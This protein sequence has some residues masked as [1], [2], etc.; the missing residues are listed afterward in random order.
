[1][2]KFPPVE[3]QLEAILRG[4]V[5]CY[6][7]EDLKKRLTASRES[8]K[9][10]RV[11]LG[12]DPTAPNIHIGHTVVLGKMRLFQDFGHTAV[13]IVGDYTAM[14]GDP[15]GKSK[16]RKSMT[17]DE[18]NAAAKTYFDQVGTVIDVKKAEIRRN[19]EWFSKMSFGD[20]MRLAGRITV[21]RI[22]ERDDFAKR[23]ANQTPISLHELMYPMMQAYDSIAI[24]ADVELGGTDQTFNLLMGRRLMEDSNLKPQICLTTPLLPGLDGVEKMSKSL[25]NTIDVF[26]PPDEM[27]GKT[28]SI[29][30][31]QMRN[32]FTLL[33]RIPMA[34]VEILLDPKQ[35]NPRMSKDRLAQEIVARY[36]GPDA[37]KKASEE[38]ARR[39]RDKGLPTDIPTHKPSGAIVPI[40]DLLLEVG[41]SASKGEARRS[42]EQKGVRLIDEKASADGEVIADVNAKIETR[43]GL[44]LRLGKHRYVRFS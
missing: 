35:T 14:V 11:K 2:T 34:E 18:V 24:E 10:L 37:A 19:G 1:M 17:E 28:M 41:F 27:F 6:S 44:I 21:A 4:A 8:G 25:G 23:Y 15:S 36:H 7:A 42:I 12:L 22:L 29:A 31:S 43:K 39:F 30:D 9:P 38:F 40:V 33:T 13:L 5:E 16:T 20:V 32:W 26:D 3:E